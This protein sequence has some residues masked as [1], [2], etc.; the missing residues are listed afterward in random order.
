MSSNIDPSIPP[1]T[2]PQTSDVRANFQIAKDEITALQQSVLIGGPTGPS[3]INGAT[4]PTGPA[5][6]SSGSD[7]H[8]FLLIGA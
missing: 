4:G 8:H 5:S 2:N 1:H 3:G 6:S 7:F